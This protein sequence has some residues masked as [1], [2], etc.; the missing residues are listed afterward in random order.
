MSEIIVDTSALVA[1]FVQ[2]EKHHHIAQRYAAQHPTAQLYLINLCDLDAGKGV[3]FKLYPGWTYSA[4]RA[5]VH[6]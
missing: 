4:Q 5:S 6:Q 1:F 2:S 3:H